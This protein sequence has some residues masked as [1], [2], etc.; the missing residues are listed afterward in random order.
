[1]R[2]MLLQLLLLLLIFGTLCHE[3][4]SFVVRQ[5]SNSRQAGSHRSWICG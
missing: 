2:A 4:S 5:L 1:M 3:L